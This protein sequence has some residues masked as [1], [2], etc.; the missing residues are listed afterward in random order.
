MGSIANF[1]LLQSDALDDLVDNATIVTRKGMFGKGIIDNYWSFLEK[2]AQALENF[3]GPGYIYAALF[4]FLEEVREIDLLTNE[5][6]GIMA[7]LVKK[8]GTGQFIFTQSQKEV[9]LS[10]IDPAKFSLEEL[11]LFNEDFSG[12]GDKE[13]AKLSMEALRLL[14]EHIGKIEDGQQL[15]LLVIG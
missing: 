14:Y 1:Y 2:N 13:T 8:R 4:T 7:R 12:E 5:Y 10:K 9:L 15:L 11:R 6:D 3:S